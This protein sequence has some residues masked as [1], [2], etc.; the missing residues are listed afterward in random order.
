M[1]KRHTL[2]GIKDMSHAHTCMCHNGEQNGV[3]FGLHIQMRQDQLKLTT[4]QIAGFQVCS[5][6][7]FM[8]DRECIV[9]SSYRYWPCIGS[10]TNA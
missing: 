2:I 9:C 6:F 7:L 3:S 10:H 8:S 4:K 5:K 1:Q